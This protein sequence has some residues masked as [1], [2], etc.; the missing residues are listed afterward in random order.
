MT[1]ALSKRL[2]FLKLLLSDMVYQIS[3]PNI[4]TATLSKRFLK[5]LEAVVIK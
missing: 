1:A 5:V 4:M 2:L 3:M